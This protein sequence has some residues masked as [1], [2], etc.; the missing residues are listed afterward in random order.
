MRGLLDV[1]SSHPAMAKT[2]NL[3]LAQLGEGKVEMT[4]ELS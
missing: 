1:V 4:T 2:I 3:L